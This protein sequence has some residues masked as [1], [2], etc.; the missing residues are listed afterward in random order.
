MQLHE[1]TGNSKSIAALGYSN[2]SSMG[3]I[4]CNQLILLIGY[5]RLPAV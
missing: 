1:S 5:D 4:I 3:A 2:I